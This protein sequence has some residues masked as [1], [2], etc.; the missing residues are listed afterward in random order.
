MTLPGIFEFAIRRKQDV[1]LSRLRLV[2]IEQQGLASYSP[3]SS[4]ANDIGLGSKA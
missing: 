4:L 3:T 1:D 2:A